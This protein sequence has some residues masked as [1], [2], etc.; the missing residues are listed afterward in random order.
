MRERHREKDSFGKIKLRGCESCKL[1]VI[2]MMYGHLPTDTHSRHRYLIKFTACVRESDEG[3]DHTRFKL[4]IG[5]DTG[6]LIINLFVLYKQVISAVCGVTIFSTEI[7]RNCPFLSALCV[8]D[9]NGQGAG[10]E[11]QWRVSCCQ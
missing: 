1:P 2:K 9:N 7:Q 4:S 10:A 5:F 3:D 8:P 6:N 11:E